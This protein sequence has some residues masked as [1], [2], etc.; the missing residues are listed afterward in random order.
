VIYATDHHLTPAC[1]KRIIYEMKGAEGI[2]RSWQVVLPILP[3]ST[4]PQHLEIEGNSWYRKV[5]I[6][7]NNMISAESLNLSGFKHNAKMLDRKAH[8]ERSG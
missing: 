5:A 8:P 3:F 4:R 6:F 1:D 2:S 7:P